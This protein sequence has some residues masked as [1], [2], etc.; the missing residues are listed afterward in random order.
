MFVFFSAMRDN[1]SEVSH[2]QS[3]QLQ[4]HH[5]IVRFT[6]GIQL[7]KDISQEAATLRTPRGAFDLPFW[8][9]VQMEAPTFSVLH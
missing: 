4:L 1:L 8:L 3:S 2:F 6:R 5:W 7:L 9:R